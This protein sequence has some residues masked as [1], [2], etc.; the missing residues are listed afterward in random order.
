ME[1]LILVYERPR[2]DE[3]DTAIHL[4]DGL[5]SFRPCAAETEHSDTCHVG[6]DTAITSH[7]V[8]ALEV[9]IFNEEYVDTY[10]TQEEKE[11]AC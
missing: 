2:S 10:A 1:A 4:G 9:C 7:L 11:Q 5:E 3:L 6:Y 8:V